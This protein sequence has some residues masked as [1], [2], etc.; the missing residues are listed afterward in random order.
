MN[1]ICLFLVLF[2]M[3]PVAIAITTTVDHILYDSISLIA[4]FKYEVESFLHYSKDFIITTALFLIES[5]EEEIISRH[6]DYP[7]ASAEFSYSI[8]EDMYE[9]SRGEARINLLIEIRVDSDER[10]DSKSGHSHS[11]RNDKL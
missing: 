10:D 6:R 4:N 3:L 7:T 9:K 5:I 11:H 1:N 8:V 2:L